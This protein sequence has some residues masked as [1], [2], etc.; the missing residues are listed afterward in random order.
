MKFIQY[1]FSQLNF[2]KQS[3]TP[4]N[5][6]MCVGSVNNKKENCFFRAV[7]INALTNNVYYI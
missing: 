7:K 3:N 2:V 6:K 5:S 1:N 4:V